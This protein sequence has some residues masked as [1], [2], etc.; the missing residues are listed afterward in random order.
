MREITVEGLIELK[1][2]IPIDVRSPGEFNEF[3]IPGAVNIPLFSDEE[4]VII[5][6]LYKQEGSDAAKWQAMEIVSPKIPS[7]LGQIKDLQVDNHHPVIY[8]W[9]GGMRSKA[10]ATFLSFA[11][12]STP[13]LTGGYRAYRQF[14]L[15]KIPSFLPPRAITLHGMTGVG[16]TDVLKKLSDRG[17]PI[18]DLEELAGHRGSIFGTIGRG[19][20]NNQK[21]FDALLF[22]TLTK[23][24]GTPF[25]ILEAESKRIGKIVQPEELINRKQLGIH[26]NLQA[27][28][29]SR[30]ERIY[31]DYV[32]PYLKDDWFQEKVIELLAFIKKR[33]K[34]QEINSLLD[35]AA[36]GQN[37]KLVIQILLE[38]YYDPRYAHKQSE[39]EGPFL[40]VDADHTDLAVDEVIQIIQSQNALVR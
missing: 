5:G 6:T 25:F 40:H 35:E 33:L 14:I 1:K 19:A 22:Q 26:I 7:I 27:S 31:H 2:A 12:I 38:A 39:Y 29:S 10:V 9:R 3:R 13:R 8:C 30:V 32:M 18:I 20:G 16:K 15:E 23:I 36:K 21:T 28:M 34:N 4:R 37:Y 11:G 17:F 24:E